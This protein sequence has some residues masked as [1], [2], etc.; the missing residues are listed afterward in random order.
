MA[1]P[2][3]RPASITV[4]HD[5]FVAA[6][7]IFAATALSRTGPS[8]SVSIV[9][10]CPRA[11]SATASTGPLK[12]ISGAGDNCAQTSMTSCRRPRSPGRCSRPKMASRR[13]RTVWSSSSTDALILSRT[14]PR[15]AR[16]AALCKLSPTAKIRWITVSR[17]SAAMRSRSAR[18][19]SSRRRRCSS[20][21]RFWERR[22]R[23]RRPCV[24]TEISTPS[25]AQKIAR[26]AITAAGAATGVSET[27]TSVR[28]I[29]AITH[30][31][32]HRRWNSA[33]HTSGIRITI[34]TPDVEPAARRSASTDAV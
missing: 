8:A 21:L 17:R 34:P 2:S 31:D 7:P 20:S 32:S 16:D 15:G 26:R 12:L 22:I 28:T 1:A 24:A 10:S 5:P 13:I 4:R 9:T 25:A 6:M 23:S 27:I 29:A 19:V 14:S 33:V 30:T 18:T 11:R 3:W